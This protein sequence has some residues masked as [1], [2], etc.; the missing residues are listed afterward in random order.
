MENNQKPFAFLVF[1]YVT[2]KMTVEIW[3]NKKTVNGN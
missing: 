1:V 2:L 3:I